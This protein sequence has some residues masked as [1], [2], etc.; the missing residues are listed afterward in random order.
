MNDLFKKLNYKQDAIWVLNAPEGFD[1]MLEGMEYVAA[2]HHEVKPGDEIAFAIGFA[3]TQSQLDA[4]IHA[5]VPH[6]KGDAL[7]WLCYPKGTSKKYRC[8][9]NRDTGWITVGEYG[10]EPVRQ[11][12][13]D[14][15]WSALR[16]RNVE[17]IKK[18]TRSDAMIL[19]KAGKAKKSKS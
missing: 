17:F 12:A 9:F 4:L 14:E 5:V 19:S 15:D 18:M 13:I 10:Y 6:L 11:V 1:A 16:F 3:T 8:D 7:L 2:I